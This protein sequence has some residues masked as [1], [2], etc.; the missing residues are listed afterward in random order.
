MAK[1]ILTIDDIPQKI[2]KPIIDYLEEKSIPVVMFVVGEEAV[3]D[4]DTL[5]YAIK[6]GIILG[7]H[8]YTHPF[9]SQMSMEECIEEIEKNEKVLDQAYRMAGEARRA[10]LFR[11]PY[12]DKGGDNMKHLQDYLRENG[13]NRIDDSDVKSETYKNSGWNKDYDIT[14]SYDCQEYNIP[15]QGVTIEYI[16]DRLENGDPNAGTNA[17]MDEGTNI[18]LLHSHDDTQAIVHDYYKLILEKMLS[19]GVEFVTAKIV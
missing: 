7:N 19:A 2:T 5:V 13:F 15:Q 10:K 11:F 8:S 1:A 6:H 18:I 16:L 4:M 17:L 9:F 3:K 14:C 12:L